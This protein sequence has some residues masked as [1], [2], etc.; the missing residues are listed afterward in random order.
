VAM[1]LA[2]RIPE[3]LPVS[4]LFKALSDETRVRIVALLA[5]EELCVCHIEAAL[6]LSQPNASRH[7][8]ILRSAQIVE[9]RRQANWIYYSI[10]RQDDPSRRAQLRTLV[11]SFAKSDMLKKDVARLLETKGPLKCQ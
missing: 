1:S 5:H 9:T 11:N 2:H 8:A 3:A 4:Q 6:G 10:A 7:L